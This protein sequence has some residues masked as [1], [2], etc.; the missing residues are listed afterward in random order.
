[1]GQG[2][3]TSNRRNKAKPAS[4]SH[5][6]ETCVGS[7]AGSSSGISAIH[8]PMN[9]SQTRAAVIVDAEGATRA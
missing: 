7:S 9:S 1:M 4:N 2:F 5:Q 8:W 3:H 6:I